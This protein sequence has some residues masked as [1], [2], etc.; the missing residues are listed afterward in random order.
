M[1]SYQFKRASLLAVG[2]VVC[3]VFAAQG[4]GSD[5]TSQV[6]P[7]SAGGSAGSGTSGSAGSAGSG[8]SGTGGEAGDSAGGSSGSGTAGSSGSAGT[9]GQNCSGPKGCYTCAPTDNN[10]DQ[11]HNHCTVG[12]CDCTSGECTQGFDNTT[13]TLPAGGGLPPLVTPPTPT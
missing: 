11:F 1:S 4:C 3:A 7:P 8:T 13:L 2:A 9:G 5:N 12:G 10:N 6:T